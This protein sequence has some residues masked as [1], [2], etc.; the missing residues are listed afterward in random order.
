MVLENFNYKIGWRGNKTSNQF[1]DFINTDRVYL[2][3][4]SNNAELQLNH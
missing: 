4:A 2:R 1:N 3:A